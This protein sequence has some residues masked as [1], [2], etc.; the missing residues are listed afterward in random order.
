MMGAVGFLTFGF[1]QAVC[2]RSPL[3]FHAGEVGP[4]YL[5]VSGVAYELDT[6]LH[7]PVK[8]VPSMENMT[9]VL[10][11]PINAAGLDATFLFQLVNQHC[12][13]VITPNPNPQFH[14]IT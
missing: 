4:G 9:N 8:G 6:W 5:I 14:T 2:P 10:Y 7:P 11:P 13:G 3:R 1:T 12:Y